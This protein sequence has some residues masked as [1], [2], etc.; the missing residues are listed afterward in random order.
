[1]KKQV[2]AI[3]LFALI[4]GVIV[5]YALTPSDREGGA[6]TSKTTETPPNRF[7]ASNIDSGSRPLPKEFTNSIGMT[8][9]YISPGEFMMGSPEDEAGRYGHETLH[10]VALSRGFFLQTT[11]TTQEQ[12]ETVMQKN[13]SFFKRCPKC[14]VEQVSWN[15]V[16]RFLLKLNRSEHI[17]NKYRLPTEAE[18]EYACRA[19]TSSAFH[20]G[21]IPD[22]KLANFGVSFIH[23]ECKDI[24]PGRT[25]R[26]ASFPPNAWGLYDMHGNVWEWC[27]DR[28]DLYPVEPVTDPVGAYSSPRR[29]YRGGSWDVESRFCRSAN[30]DSGFPVD[31]IAD[32]G[33]RVA[34]HP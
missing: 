23:D 1:M 3:V 33:F 17:Y 30:R 12:W 4:F 16:N 31:R 25:M 18:W 10:R 5:Y 11:E 15:D 19:G 22:C 32:V 21:D 8:F 24:N 28:F 29:V 27:R 34:L 6:K 2:F 14:P 7:P 20:W 9:V 13:P 26:V